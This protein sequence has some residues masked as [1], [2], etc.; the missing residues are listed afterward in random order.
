MTSIVI[1]THK[2]N[3]KL[4]RLLKSIPKNKFEII[5]VNN[6]MSLAGK[7]NYGYKKSKGKHILFIDDDNE[8]DF[9][10]VENLEKAIRRNKTGIAGMLGCYS[11]KRDTICDGG[12]T[13][14]LTTGFTKAKHFNQKVM[15]WDNIFKPY[16]VDEVANSF[17]VR[18]SLIKKIGLFDEERF[19]I[20]LDEADLCLRA[21]RAGYK[22]VIVPNAVTFHDSITY[23]RIPNFRRPK[24]AYY[25]GRNRILF[26][27]K[28]H[29]PL[30]YIPVFI[31][32]YVLCLIWRFKFKLIKHFLKGVKDGIFNI[33]GSKKE[34]QV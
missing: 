28:H 31:L 10:A 34:Y 18:R 12:D 4:K 9:R 11:D 24:N 8:L 7:R 14:N 19:P 21:K 33:A 32:S 26:Q 20:D 16:E 22:V 1:P 5:V 17:M 3:D 23:S 2:R 29:L 25:V 30:R 6:N 13:R 15:I 27:K